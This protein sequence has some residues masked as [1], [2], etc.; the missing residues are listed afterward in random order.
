MK[1]N[2]YISSFKTFLLRYGIP[3]MLIMAVM[4]FAVNFI[5]EKLIISETSGSGAS[6]VNRILKHRSNDELVI[7]GSSRAEGSIVPD[8]LD[9][10]SFNYGLAGTQ[11]NVW[12]YFLQEELKKNN[13]RPILI[14]FDLDGLGYRNGD[15]LY[16]LFNSS[17][18]IV[19]SFIDDW[20]PRYA[21]P[22]IKHMGYFERYISNFIQERHSVTEIINKGAILETKRRTPS[23]FNL[24]VQERK[25]EHLFFKNDKKLERELMLV[26]HNN[27]KRK[28]IFFIPPY[29]ELYLKSI[30]NYSEALS[31]LSVLDSIPNV[32]ILNFSHFKMDNAYFYNT[33][34]LNYNGALI[35][36]KL[37]K[38]DV[39][40]LTQ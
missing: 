34:H 9:K 4:L 31:F 30:E 36:T 27:K 32:R 18:P 12:I 13:R 16:W 7:L 23:E 20:K 25:K 28:I 24:L 17:N 38:D 14:N 15:P 29:H 5:F 39:A 22:V 8:S 10:H 21:I 40:N 33:A 35:F 19:R 1:H 11:D 3:Y 26:L 37:I 2:S 6:K